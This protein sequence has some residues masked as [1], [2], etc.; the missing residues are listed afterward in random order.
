M[1]A[2]FDGDEINCHVPQN[3]IAA[4]EVNV[5]MATPFHILSPKNGLTIICTAQD[6]MMSMYLL[7]KRKKQIER[8]MFMQYL[9]DLDDLSRFNEIVSK[10]SFTAKDLFSFLLPRQLW[11]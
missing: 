9:V 2:D 7:T 8:W 3:P 10:L 1:N 6:A 5:L 11:H 4:T